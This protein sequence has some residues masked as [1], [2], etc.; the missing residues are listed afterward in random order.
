MSLSPNTAPAAG[1]GPI[2]LVES[3]R[4]LPLASLTVA[5]R[6]GAIEDPVGKEGLTRLC[7]RLMRRT[8]GGLAPHLV[9]TRIDSLGAGLGPEVGHSIAAFHGTVIARS[10]DPLVDLLEDML[11]RPGLDDGELA[12]L[13][14]E[15]Q[16]EIV[17]A[18]DNDRSLARRWFRRKLFGDHAYAR[19]VTGSLRSVQAISAADVRAQVRQL[20]VSGNLVF[21]FAGDLDE[22]AAERIARRVRDAL[23]DGAARED[24]AGEP[25]ARSGRHLVLVDKPERTQTQILIGGLGTHPKDPDH[26]PLSVA[27]TIFGGTFT[28]RMTREVR[29]KR[30]WSYGAYASVPFDR[31]R[32]AFSM[33]TFPK[34]ED[35][36]PCI[37]LELAMLHDWRE[38]GVTRAELT[39]AKRY[40]TRS[41]AFSIDTAGKRVGLEL[42]A[43][44]YGLP[45]DYYARYVER[46]QAVTLEQ[47]NEAIQKRISERDLL[48]VVVGTEAVIGEPV[49]RVIPDLEG[50]EIV[51]YDSDAY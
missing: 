51:P 47:V 25:S 10:L 1:G 4:A 13:V 32:Q 22:A 31:H 40:L 5:L 7:A 33:W 3:S 42:D 21:A 20:F 24:G 8:A 19:S 49:R 23:P 46:V 36:A 17:E 44:L 18:R 34:A 6:T 41:H 16:A 15:T 37:E 2:V 50:V 35:A 14:R 30:G 12:R 11:A 28:A 29:S 48:V 45:P 39:W 38:R 27:T 43:L 9:D 26:L